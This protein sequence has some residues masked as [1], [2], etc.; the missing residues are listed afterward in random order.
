MRRHFKTVGI[1]ALVVVIATVVAG[2][3]ALAARPPIEPGHG[4]FGGRGGHT[5]FGPMGDNLAGLL[6]FKGAFGFGS[7]GPLTSRDDVQ[8]ATA[9][10]L[11]MT[12]EELEDALDEKTLFEIAREQ[13]VHVADIQD[14]VQSVHQEALQQAVEDGDLTQEQADLIGEKTGDRAFGHREANMLFGGFDKLQAGVE[15]TRTALAESL[16]MTV[17]QLEAALDEKSLSEIAKEQNVDMA[18]VQDAMQTAKKT[19]LEEALQQAV[20]DGTLT[21]EQADLAGAFMALRGAGPRGGF[22]GGDFGFFGRGM[23]GGDHAFG[24][25]MTG[26]DRDHAFGPGGMKG[27]RT[28]GHGLSPL[29]HLLGGRK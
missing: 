29:G 24:K 1:A 7:D 14:A 9:E 21:Q 4:P 17:D 20:E 19:M 11:G 22:P 13:N 15:T 16:G 18:D 2:S 6:A 10:A 28:R 12:V 26:G 23:M 25:G 5:P 8:A 27:G 3:T